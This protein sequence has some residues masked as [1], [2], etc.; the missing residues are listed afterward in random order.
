MPFGCSP[1]QIQQALL[2]FIVEL[3]TTEE[4][5]AVKNLFFVPVGLP[6]MGKSTLAKNIRASCQNHLTHEAKAAR[7][8]YAQTGAPSNSLN[9]ISS[10]GK[11]LL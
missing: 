11:S 9:E 10:Q 5:H 8:N 3:T 4:M 2:K 6:G 1:E 7:F